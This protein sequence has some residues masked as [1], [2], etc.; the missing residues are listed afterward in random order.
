MSKKVPCHYIN[1]KHRRVHFEHPE[2]PR[3]IQLVEVPDDFSG[4]AFC[5]LTCK[6]MH[7]GHKKV[8][9]VAASG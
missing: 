9:E 3:G 7:D 6:L 1:C 2:E 8:E 5:S 4:Q